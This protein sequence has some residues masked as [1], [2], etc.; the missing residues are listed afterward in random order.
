[1]SGRNV[2]V[3]PTGCNVSGGPVSTP[4]CV[5]HLSDCVGV[6]ESVIWEIPTSTDVYIGGKVGGVTGDVKLVGCVGL[7]G[8]P[9]EG[10]GPR[11][12]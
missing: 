4:C 11:V 2:L 7:V 10:G 9:R 5:P 6:K 1:M 8:L 3:A 12:V